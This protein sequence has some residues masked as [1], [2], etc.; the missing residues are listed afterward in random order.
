MAPTIVFVPGFWE[1][2]TVFEEVISLLKPIGFKTQ[3]AALPSTGTVSPGNPDMNDDIAAVRS[4]VQELVDAE[5]DVLMVLHSGGGF[6]GT[7][8][9]EGLTAK[10]RTEK[11]LKGGVAK[12]VLLTA[13]IF[14]EGF[15]HGPLPFQ[16][17]QG[18]AMYCA[19][20]E[21]LLF[22]DLSE[23][24]VEKWKKAL[25]SQPASGWDGTITY[26]GW[27][28]VPS[29]YL[30][31]ENDQCIPQPLQEQLAG[32]AGSRIEKCTAGHM[33]MLSMPR[34]VADIIISAAA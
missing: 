32:A 21:K 23:N 33:V 5:E 10:A 30:V 14:P 29:V 1:G 22:N 12:L 19:T 18:G 28:D 3:V 9:I 34:K 15:T 16:I 13:A 8:A 11:G 24:D 2:P 31:C 25:K 6:I 7:S 27:K 20:P 4:V 26:A 17:T